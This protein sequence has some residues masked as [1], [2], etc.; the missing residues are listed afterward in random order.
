MDYVVGFISQNLVTYK[1]FVEFRDSRNFYDVLS[2]E[3]P[4]TPDM[5]FLRKAR[6][7]GNGLI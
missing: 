5:R 6:K 2:G 1:S 4:V 3:S 7:L